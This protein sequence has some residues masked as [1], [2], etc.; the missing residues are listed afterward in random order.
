[1]PPSLQLT[2]AGLPESSVPFLDR[3]CAPSTHLECWGHSKAGTR[4]DGAKA[5]RLLS[6]L[7]GL[8][9]FRASLCAL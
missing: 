3:C 5:P 9:N 1:M 8:F 4:P 2:A 7:E 6:D